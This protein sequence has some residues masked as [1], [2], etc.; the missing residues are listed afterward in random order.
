M[1]INTDGFY[2]LEHKCLPMWHSGPGKTVSLC[3][4]PY[5]IRVPRDVPMFKMV[6]N[7][8]ASTIQ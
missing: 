3:T 1:E 8:V 4:H 6:S 5:L 2:I 7:F